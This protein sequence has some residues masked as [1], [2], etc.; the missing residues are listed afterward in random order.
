MSSNSPSPSESPNRSSNINLSL[1]SPIITRRTRT[2]STSARALENPVE[3]G[4]IKIFCRSK[5]HGFITPHSGG[6]DIF[7]HI[8]DIEGEY[9]P[10][11][12]DEVKY[13]LCIIPPKYEKHQAVHCQIINFCATKHKKWEDQYYESGNK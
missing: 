6:D 7:V 12:G 3:K 9:V 11:P 13:R 5:G 1:P 4:M 10:M 2:S 8:S